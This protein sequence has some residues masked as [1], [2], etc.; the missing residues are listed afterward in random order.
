[1][2]NCNNDIYLFNILL[3]G[4]TVHTGLTWWS[5]AFVCIRD[6]LAKN[7]DKVYN[8]RFNTQSFIKIK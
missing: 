3:D 7:N 8:K 4:S 1:M 6:Y 5:S 2:V